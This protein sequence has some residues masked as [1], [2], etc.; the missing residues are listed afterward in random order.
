M[1][2][3]RSIARRRRRWGRTRDIFHGQGR[4]GRMFMMI[5]NMRRLI[6]YGSRRMILYRSRRMI[7]YGSGRLILY[8][9]GRLILYR[10]RRLILYGSRRLILYRMVF[11]FR[12]MILNRRWGRGRMT[13]SS[14]IFLLGRVVFRR[15][16][17]T[18]FLMRGKVF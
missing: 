8:R 11:V 18:M 9:S 15:R 5:F 2:H 7:L 17:K 13:T 6:L 14:R 1:I 3:R 16:G 10:S 4:W 12:R